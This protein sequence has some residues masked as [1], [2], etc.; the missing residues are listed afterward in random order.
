K[1]GEPFLGS[2]I[3]RNRTVNVQLSH[4]GA[5][6]RYPDR[7]LEPSSQRRQVYETRP[8]AA[9][10]TGARSLAVQRRPVLWPEVI[11][12]PCSQRTLPIKNRYL[13][14]G[15]GDRSCIGAKKGSP[16]WVPAERLV[17]QVR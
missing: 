14:T 1:S 10:S 16:S 7:T 12:A 2:Q 9:G 6:K 15:A 5:S 17:G 13:A 8:R 3:A 4:T 11:G